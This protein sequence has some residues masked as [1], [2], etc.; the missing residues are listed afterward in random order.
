MAADNQST[1]I[2][3]FVDEFLPLKMKKI[4]NYGFPVNHPCFLYIVCVAYKQLLHLFAFMS[5]FYKMVVIPWEEP[6]VSVPE[7]SSNNMT[8]RNQ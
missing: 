7:A 3:Q 6:G 8:S 4:F 5:C 1:K 2:L